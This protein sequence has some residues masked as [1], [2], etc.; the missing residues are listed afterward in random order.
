MYR[1]NVAARIDRAY[2]T[3]KSKAGGSACLPSDL[4]SLTVTVLLIVGAFLF[5]YVLLWALITC[6][7][8][9]QIKLLPTT[10]LVSQSVMCFFID[11]L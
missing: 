8:L 10:I 1:S 6:Q 9:V 5:C 4:V 7:F 2:A 3:P 11:A